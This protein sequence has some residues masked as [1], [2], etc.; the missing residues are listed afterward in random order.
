[1]TI[2]NSMIIEK[3]ETIRKLQAE[4]IELIRINTVVNETIKQNTKE[5]E[6]NE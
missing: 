3:Q 2:L 6:T 1:M 5:V 4:L